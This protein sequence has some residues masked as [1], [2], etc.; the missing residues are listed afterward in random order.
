[1]IGAL[2]TFGGLLVA[3][4]LYLWWYWHQLDTPETLQM[5]LIRAGVNGYLARKVVKK[6]Q[7]KGVDHDS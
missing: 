6:H 7:R 5:K 4:L 1:M 3:Y 2:L